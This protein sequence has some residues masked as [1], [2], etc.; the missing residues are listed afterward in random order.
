MRDSTMVETTATK[1]F[2]L[3]LAAGIF[4]AGL[5]QI[6]DWQESQPAPATSTAGAYTQVIWSQL[7]P[8]SI[9]ENMSG[10]VFN[11]ILT[12]HYTILYVDATDK[13]VE[14]TNQQ[15]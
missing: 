14:V 5:V 6:R 10:T 7:A 2:L 1:F 9:I 4:G 3:I 11:S 8:S 12:A 13:V 15:N